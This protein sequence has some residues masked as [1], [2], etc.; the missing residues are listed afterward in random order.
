[1][2]LIPQIYPFFTFNLYNYYYFYI[3]VFANIPYFDFSLWY[4]VLV[5]AKLV[6]VEIDKNSVKKEAMLPI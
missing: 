1:M 5:I 4:F 6:D 2:V 3:L